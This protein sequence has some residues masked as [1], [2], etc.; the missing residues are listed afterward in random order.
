MRKR[1]TFWRTILLISAVLSAS[2]SCHQVTPGNIQSNSTNQTAIRQSPETAGQVAVDKGDLKL[3]YQARKNT[4][5]STTHTV[6]SKPQALEKLIAELNQRLSLPFDMEVSF[7]DC[8]QPDAY[9]E[10]E[11]HQI[12]L[13]YQLIDDYYDLFAKKIKDKAKLDDAVR[14]ATAATFF[15][16]LGHGLVDAWKIP[17]TGREEDAVDQLSTVVLIESTEAG[18]QMALDGALTFKLYA[19]LAKGEKK[20]YWDEHSLD[21]QRFFDTICLVYGHDEEKY[22][23]LV[24]NGTLPEERAAFCTEDYDKVSRSWRQLLAPYLKQPAQSRPKLKL[25]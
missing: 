3:R 12:K 7:E 5:A 16:E 2:S 4:S 20:I 21:E 9:Y 14:A 10:P 17:T 18:D 19:D 8:E 23:Y 1:D 24:K 22:A 25:R 15:H 13:C 6:G 11:T